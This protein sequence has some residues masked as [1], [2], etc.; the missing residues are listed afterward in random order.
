MLE[1]FEEPYKLLVDN[2]ETEFNYESGIIT[3]T[4]EFSERIITLDYF[5]PIIEE[6]PEIEP[7]VESVVSSPTGS[8]GKRYITQPTPPKPTLNITNKTEDVEVSEPEPDS[9]LDDELEDIIVSPEPIIEEESNNDLAIQFTI[10]F[11]VI[12]VIAVGKIMFS[13]KYS[14]KIFGKKYDKNK[15]EE[16]TEKEE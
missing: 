14:E 13:K 6:E 5:V 11:I 8:G 2:N 4:T 1:G 7:E 16:E 10:I 3:F 9:Y 12:I 15:N